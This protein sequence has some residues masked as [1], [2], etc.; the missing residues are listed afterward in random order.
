MEAAAFAFAGVVDPVTALEWIYVRW[1]CIGNIPHTFLAEP[2]LDVVVVFLET[3]GF[4]PANVFLGGALALD[5]VTFVAAGLAAD[6]AAEDFLAAAV[7][8][9]VP[10]DFAAVAVAVVLG[11]A[12]FLA[13]A[14][15]GAAVLVV[16]GLVATLGLAAGLF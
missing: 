9:V 11:L 14:A 7:V 12:D 10:V 16:F 1:C 3:G 4:F 13:A 2:R 5:D 8:L 15:L 6:L